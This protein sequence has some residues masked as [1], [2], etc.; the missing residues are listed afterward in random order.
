[1]SFC[2]RSLSASVYIVRHILV[3]SAYNASSVPEFNP[4]GRSLKEHGHK[5]YTSPYFVL[6]IKTF[7]LAVVPNFKN[8]QGVKYWNSN[9]S[10]SH[11]CSMLDIRPY[12]I[13]LRWS[14]YP[15]CYC[16]NKAELQFWLTQVKFFERPWN[17]VP[18]I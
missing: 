14:T 17:T 2:N 12:V 3:S 18:T 5:M 15:T 7:T 6:R 8:I 9:F 1:M 10:Y 4:S 16:G 11:I 13:T